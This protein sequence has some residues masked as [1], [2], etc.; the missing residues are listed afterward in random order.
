[1]NL[2]IKLDRYIDYNNNYSICKGL[3]TLRQEFEKAKKY[4]NIEYARDVVI[5]AQRIYNKVIT[6]KRSGFI[7]DNI[8]SK[9]QG[10]IVNLTKRLKQEFGVEIAN[11]NPS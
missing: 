7:V 9:T 10:F 3:E 4:E 1:M 8:S 5:T 2:F 6:I 11:E